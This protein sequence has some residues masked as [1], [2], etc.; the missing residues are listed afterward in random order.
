MT[1]FYLL[2]KTKTGCSCDLQ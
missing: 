1:V 2:M